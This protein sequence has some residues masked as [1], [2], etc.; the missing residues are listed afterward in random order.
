MFIAHECTPCDITWDA[1]LFLQSGHA[2]LDRSASCLPQALDKTLG[3][4]SI[5]SNLLLDQCAARAER[6]RSSEGGLG[7]HGDG[8]NNPLLCA[9]SMCVPIIHC[10]VCSVT[11]S[12]T[13]LRR[14]RG[15]EGSGAMGR[16]GGLDGNPG[17]ELHRGRMDNKAVLLSVAFM[18]SV[19]RSLPAHH[20][21]MPRPLGGVCACH[22]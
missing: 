14:A 18:F 11:R 6:E 1:H 4:R 20:A 16:L 2:F 12:R 17:R 7:K 3:D 22:A 19:V 5:R 8:S 9:P 15:R 13:K 21:V 10:Y